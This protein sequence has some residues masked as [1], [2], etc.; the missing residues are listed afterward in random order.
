[1]IN[2]YKLFIARGSFC[3]IIT[4]ALD[5]CTRHKYY[6]YE[7]VLQFGTNFVWNNPQVFIK[8]NWQVEE[9]KAGIKKKHTQM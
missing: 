7:N 6:Q 2:S 4:Q 9:S 3:D 8:N 1:M 5:R